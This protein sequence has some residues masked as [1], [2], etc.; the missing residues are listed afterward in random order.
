[1]FWKHPRGVISPDTSLAIAYGATA[2][3]L[4]A[5]NN[6]WVTYNYP[7]F[8]D[9]LGK[10]PWFVIVEVIFGFWNACNDPLLGW[11]SDTA[12][13]KNNNRR[14][15]H[16]YR[17]GWMLPLA[18]LVAWFPW[19]NGAGSVLAAL[20]FL[21]SLCLYDGALTYVE[22]NYA[23]LLADLSAKDDSQ[24]RARCNFFSSFFA[25][26]GSCSSIFA[27]VLW[28]EGNNMTS[29]RVFC[30]ILAVLSLPGF[31]VTCSYLKN[32]RFEESEA[33]VAHQ[34][35][36][37]SMFCHQLSTQ[38]NF[39]RFSC[40]RLIQVFLCTFE[41]NHLCLFLHVL[42]GPFL[43]LS[44]MGILISA[45]FVL[46]HVAI[47]ALTP[48]VQKKGVYAVFQGILG[49]KLLIPMAVL[50][51]AWV[52]G[53]G[54]LTIGN[55]GWLLIVIYICTAR[56]VT[57]SVCRLF[58]LVHSQLVDED[59][60]LHNRPRSMAASLIGTS[61]LFAKPGESLAPILGWRIL[62]LVG[63][64]T[65]T[66]EGTSLVGSPLGSADP[67]QTHSL[68]LLLFFLPLACV[69]LQYL[70]WRKFTLHGPYLKQ[71]SEELAT[72]RTAPA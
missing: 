56:V 63:T 54:G 16:I 5:I 39:A 42:A 34:E 45:C 67:S 50:G 48:F 25:I 6:V 59:H 8:L 62:S 9:R 18:F 28:Q 2:F 41:K 44:T 52:N 17:G 55:P 51:A 71:I 65:D 7:Y 32:Y 38:G 11:L 30:L 35:L 31:Q 46:P 20:H 24:L 43:S 57:E 64:P 49:F 1:M 66:A 27:H 29:F 70:L 47:M 26:L 53:S 3:S 23:S 14:L 60:Y 10:G 37:I 22:V 33:P 4:A 15:P 61:A 72:R 58:P 40:I 19:D 68:I 21:C 12:K 36:A 69:S 13:M